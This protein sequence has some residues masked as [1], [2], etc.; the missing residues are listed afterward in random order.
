MTDGATGGIQVAVRSV[1][2][3][4]HQ[5]QRHFIVYLHEKDGDRFLGIHVG[6]SEGTAIALALAGD[7]V[8]R[9]MTHDMLKLAIVALG[10]ELRRVTISLEPE[11]HIYSADATLV[12]ENGDERHIDCRPSDALALAVR[13]DPAPAIVVPD[14]LLTC[15]SG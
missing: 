12:L 3:G 9:P 5:G 13:T 7:P 15:S 1:G 2:A 14:D 4:E 6:H 10:A 11:S 8:P